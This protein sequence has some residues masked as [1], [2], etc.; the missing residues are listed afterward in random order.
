MVQNLFKT[1]DFYY[2]YIA[3]TVTGPL[4]IYSD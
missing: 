1:I 3:S 2:K 4:A